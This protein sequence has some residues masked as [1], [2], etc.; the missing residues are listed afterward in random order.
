MKF[1]KITYSILYAVILSVLLTSCL[2]STRSKSIEEANRDELILAVGSE[3][4]TGFDPTTG[5][6]RYGSPLFQSTLFKRDSNLE[7]KNDLAVNYSTSDNGL[8]WIVELRKDV[9]FSDWVP[10]TA[11]DV[12]Y[13]FETARASGSIVDLTNLAKAE[14]LDSHTVKFSLNQPDSTFIHSLAVTGIV[15]KHAHSNKYFENPRGSGPYQIIQW[16]KGEGIND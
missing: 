3:P 9:T 2:S 16:N 1:N 15:P 10:L 12:T 4:E 7:M 11:D 8:E 14:A 13:T 6:G 5:W